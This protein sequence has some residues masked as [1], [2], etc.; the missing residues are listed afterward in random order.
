MNRSGTYCTVR[1][2]ISE[3]TKQILVKLFVPFLDLI[4]CFI[5]EMKVLYS[6]MLPDRRNAGGTEFL[7]LQRTLATIY[8]DGL[9]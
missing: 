5:R 4:A 2:A 7:S 6:G 8:F 3:E 9:H 1:E